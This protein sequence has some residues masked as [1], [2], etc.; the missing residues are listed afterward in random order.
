VFPI[1]DPNTIPAWRLEAL[2][3][4]GRIVA[5]EPHVG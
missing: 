5:Q 2:D 1:R 4:H 3:A